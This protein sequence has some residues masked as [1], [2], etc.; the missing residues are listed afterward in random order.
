MSGNGETS[1]WLEHWPLWL[2]LALDVAV[3][4][5]FVLIIRADEA[6]ILQAEVRRR[7]QLY[8]TAIER[9]I[10]RDLA[11]LDAI[12]GLYANQTVVS[13]EQFSRF[14]EAGHLLHDDIQA[15]EWIPRVP[16]KSRDDIEQSARRWR[17]DFEF[18]ENVD[19]RMVRAGIRDEY[20]PVLYVSPLAGNEAAIG[21]DLYSNPTRRKALARAR[22]TGDKVATGRIRLVQERAE[23][24]GFLIFRP[25]YEGGTTPSTVE[26]RRATL[27][28]YALGVY[29]IGDLIAA[30]LGNAP[31]EGVFF[32]LVDRTA[33][34]ES[35]LLYETDNYVREAVGEVVEIPIGARTWV[36]SF[37]PNENLA[38]RFGPRRANEILV[39]GIVYTGI[40][41]VFLG[42]YF[43]RLSR[44]KTALARARDKLEEKVRERTASLETEV[45]SRRQ[46]ESRLQQY[47]A[48]LEQSN[49]E[50]ESFA[51]IASHDLQEPLRKIQAFGDLLSAEEAETLADDSK[52]YI[53]SMASACSRLRNLISDL[54]S[55]SR[56]TSQGVALES[57]D[58]NELLSEVLKDLELKIVEVGGEVVVGDLPVVVGDAGLLQQLFQ[59][60]LANS[61]KFQREGAPPRITVRAHAVD[62]SGPS[63]EDRV[64]ILVEDEGIGFEQEYAEQIFDVFQRLHS[65]TRYEGTGIGLA[66][67]KRIATLHGGTI[68]ARG[69][70][71]KGSVFAV[72]LPLTQS[73]NGE[74]RGVDDPQS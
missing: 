70:K 35:G 58:L 63:G 72:A 55:L 43:V 56:V 26:A 74:S 20:F 57:L 52:M 2:A 16:A 73:P 11:V 68:K 54:L 8:A 30:S 41:A 49:R 50:L 31:P 4:L 9:S 28:G 69:E 33:P 5:I 67:C 1:S 39:G 3:T 71:G 32:Q 37:I 64:E 45:A 66:L 6:T 59:N 27:R 53:A 46:A 60:L 34:E 48:K 65:R 25:I 7:A 40:L 38:A 18:R 21:F 17:S 47:S 22:D 62:S 51:Y 29:R 24:F 23:Q 12:A 42:F 36:L 10:D 19:G 14:V 13:R 15:L 61:L 44:S